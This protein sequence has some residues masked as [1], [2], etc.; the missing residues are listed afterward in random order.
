MR[1]VFCLVLGRRSSNCRIVTVLAWLT[2]R[3]RWRCKREAGGLSVRD[4]VRCLL[5]FS[6]DLPSC[7]GYCCMVPLYC[8]VLV[9]G[10]PF[11]IC[12][13]LPQH[14]HWI[15]MSFTVHICFHGTY[16]SCLCPLTP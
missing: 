7:V 3:E 8:T 10:Y 12:G 15:Y 16:C 14:Y 13:N 1:R 2:R 4:D 11:S 5:M 6:C 9:F